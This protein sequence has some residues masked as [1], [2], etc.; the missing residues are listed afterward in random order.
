MPKGE[1]K[2]FGLKEDYHKDFQT[3]AAIAS[4]VAIKAELL[5]APDL[6]G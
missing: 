2:L 4:D 5:F 6:D 1:Y 3:T